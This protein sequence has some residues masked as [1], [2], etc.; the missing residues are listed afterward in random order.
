[1]ADAF[2]LGER[3]MQFELLKTEDIDKNGLY[4]DFFSSVQLGCF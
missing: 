3:L 4:L 2:T 1:M